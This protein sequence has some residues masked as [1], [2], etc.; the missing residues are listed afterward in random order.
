VDRQHDALKL[1]M[2]G[3][4]V[5]KIR[6]PRSVLDL[7]TGKGSWAVEVAQEFPTADEVVGVDIETLA[8]A[9]YPPNCRFEVPLYHVEMLTA[10][11]GCVQGHSVSRELLFLCPLA[12][13]DVC[14]ARLAGI[15]S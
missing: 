4:L 13:D 15:S 12:I 6:N 14:C 9:T 5:R 11:R 3:N 8:P 10:D 7:G 1:L 2:N